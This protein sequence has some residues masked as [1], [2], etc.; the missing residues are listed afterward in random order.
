MEGEIE[1]RRAGGGGGTGIEENKGSATGLYTT[2]YNYYEELR[3]TVD[4]FLQ[5][6]YD[7]THVFHGFDC[8]IFINFASWFCLTSSLSDYNFTLLIYNSVVCDHLNYR[9]LFIFVHVCQ[10]LMSLSVSFSFSFS[11]HLSLSLSLSLSLFISPSLSLFSKLSSPLYV[12]TGLKVETQI[13]RRLQSDCSVLRFK[14]L[15]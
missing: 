4:H 15:K 8:I 13:L 5:T 11:S 7:I 6:N 9:S 14:I 12:M 10:P 2:V 3:S 1:R